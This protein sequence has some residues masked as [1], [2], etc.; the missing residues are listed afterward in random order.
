MTLLNGQVVNSYGRVVAEMVST[1]TG[2]VQ[3]D[4]FNWTSLNITEATSNIKDLVLTR[5][6]GWTF[7]DEEVMMKSICVHNIKPV[8]SCSKCQNNA[9]CRYTDLMTA[10]TKCICSATKQG[11]NCDIDLCSKCQNGGFCRFMMVSNDTQCVCPRPFGGE[12]CE[13]NLC[14]HCENGGYCKFDQK[15]LVGDCICQFPFAG[16]NCD[17]RE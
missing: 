14:P 4:Y 3:I 7:M 16:K 10:K 8:E 11:D 2:V 1:Q 5:T 12:Y 17:L 15:H 9:F 6:G 13:E